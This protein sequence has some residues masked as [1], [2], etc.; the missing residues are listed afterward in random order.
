MR[1]KKKEQKNNAATEQC[2]R[3]DDAERRSSTE[4]RSKLE[5][6]AMRVKDISSVSVDSLL[7]L[8]CMGRTR[9][10]DKNDH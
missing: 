1:A 10:D 4:T 7:R 6:Q 3:G 5:A 2:N 9:A 8:S